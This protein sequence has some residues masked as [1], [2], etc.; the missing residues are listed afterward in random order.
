MIIL[1]EVVQIETLPPLYICLIGVIIII[2]LKI[3]LALI[4]FYK[5]TIK[6]I[7][8]IFPIYSNMSTEDTTKHLFI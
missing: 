6:I 8:S 5:I 1:I 7:A 4:C 2:G 3:F